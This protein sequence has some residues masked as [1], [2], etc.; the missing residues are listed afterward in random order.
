MA[1]S[2]TKNTQ[3]PPLP[4]QA[5]ALLALLLLGQ[6]LV[7]LDVSVVNVALPA[8]QD[9]LGLSSSGLQWVVNGYTIAYAGFLLL[10]GRLADVIGRRPAFVGGLGLFV[11]GSLTGGLAS[12]SG[13][14]LTGRIVQGLGAAV[15]SPATL[16]ILLASFPEGPQRAK[17][18]GWWMAIGAAGGATGG[19]VG[20]ALTEWLSWRWVLLVNVP[21]GAATL[22][23]A[24]RL[25]PDAAAARSRPRLDVPGAA[26]VTVGLGALVLGITQIEQHG[27]TAAQTLVPVAVAAVLLAAFVA[28]QQRT[29]QP[30]MPLS[31]LRLPGLAAANAVMLVSG[32]ALFAIWF[33]LTLYMQQ[34]LGYTP[35]Q[36][37]AGF[38]PHTLAI[39]AGTEMTTRRLA[40]HDPRLVIAAA[41]T[42]S[43]TG[44]VVLALADEGSGYLAGV[45]LPGILVMFG[46]G[47]AFPPVIGAAT[48]GVAPEVHGLA[49][50]VLNTAR[51]MGGALGLAVLATVAASRTSHVA[52]AAPADAHALVEG[53]QVAYLVAAGTTLLA[54]ALAWLLP[55]P[56]RTEERERRAAS[57]DAVAAP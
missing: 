46:A 51:M 34:V 42:L 26:L 57:V 18:M 7:V 3:N 22:I 50:G 29:A 1:I 19:L 39:I 44:F 5:R 56:R 20:G 8:M 41:L 24:L 30:L 2:N 23:A 38:L 25:L 43:A 15:L 33:F 45:A 54:A 36:A 17:A 11:A 21:V 40:G 37:G 35:L 48:A 4:R 14:L 13:V 52:G 53:F 9:G 49:S 16:T 27:W 12:S 32:G 31:L 6:F 10:G 28:T 47:I 55:G